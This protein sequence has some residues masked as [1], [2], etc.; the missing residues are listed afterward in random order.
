MDPTGSEEIFSVHGTC[1]SCGIGVVKLDPRLFSFNSRQ[2]ACPKCNGLGVADENETD[3]PETESEVCGACGGSRLNPA[4]LAVKVG[5]KTIWDLVQEPADRLARTLG[6][7][8][9]DAPQKPI[10]AP[11]LQELRI[12]LD[13]LNRLGLSYLSL[14][15]REKPC[16]AARPSGFAWPPN[17]DRT[18]PASPTSSMSRR[19]DCI[20]A[21]TAF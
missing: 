21:T 3:E 9:F 7:L 12:R 10:A 1:P 17:S 18:S 13:L 11:I 16:P 19:S 20:P 15:R 5:G 2:G 4:A 8:T 14:G 6:E